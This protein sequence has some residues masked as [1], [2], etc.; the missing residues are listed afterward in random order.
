[1]GLF[2]THP[3]VDAP[4]SSDVTRNL[5]RF[6]SE[7]EECR[8]CPCPKTRNLQKWLAWTYSRLRPED[9]LAMDCALDAERLADD[10]AAEIASRVKS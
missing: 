5:L 10:L 8:T 6:P 9:Q 4:Q 7:R 1:M 2:G 3:P